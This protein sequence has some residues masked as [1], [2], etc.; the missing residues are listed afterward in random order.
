MIIE[1][2]QAEGNAWFIEV[3][4]VRHV[5]DAIE[6]NCKSWTFGNQIRCKAKSVVFSNK[7]DGKKAIV[8]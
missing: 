5:V 4:G 2:I 1:I 7:K 8:S 3:D 6:I